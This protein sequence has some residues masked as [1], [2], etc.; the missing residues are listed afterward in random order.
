M[1]LEKLFKLHP[2]MLNLKAFTNKDK[3][4]PISN[5][6]EFLESSCDLVFL[7][8]VRFIVFLWWKNGRDYL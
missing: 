7:V 6:K 3:L 2:I 1:F 4:C 8:T 5:Y